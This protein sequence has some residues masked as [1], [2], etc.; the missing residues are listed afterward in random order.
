MP[1][2]DTLKPAQPILVPNIPPPS[3]ENNED[4]NI[5]VAPVKGISYRVQVFAFKEDTYSAEQIREKLKLS[6]TVS[7]EYSGGWH[8]YTIGSFTDLA[9]AKKL[10]SELRTSKE[11][12]DA[13]IAKYI[14]GK[15]ATP[16]PPHTIKHTKYSKSAK[17]KIYYHKPVHKK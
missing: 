5:M 8:R 9:E 11:I 2:Q 3:E 15:R 16:A 7:K 12:P 10:M 4:T 17:G 6:Q 14:N 1:S 13:F